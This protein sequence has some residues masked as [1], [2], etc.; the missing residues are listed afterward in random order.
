ML[1]SHADV[2]YRGLLH[3]EVEHPP[4]PL[5][6]RRPRTGVRA[7]AT[8]RET[9]QASPDVVEDEPQNLV[10]GAPHVELHDLKEPVQFTSL[11]PL[12]PETVN[13]FIGCVEG[14]SVE[15]LTD[16]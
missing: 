1:R 6:R 8:G 2:A 13:V 5:R 12:E 9:R 7:C 11:H 14:D 15:V 4:P 16:R 10:G 3:V